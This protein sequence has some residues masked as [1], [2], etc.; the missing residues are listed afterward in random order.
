[1]SGDVQDM[2]KEKGIYY[3]TD[4][5]YEMIRNLGGDCGN[6]NHRPIVCLVKSIEH[7]ELYWLFQW[8]P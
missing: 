6:P 4:S 8:D 2:I 1:M 7:P 5:F 3:A